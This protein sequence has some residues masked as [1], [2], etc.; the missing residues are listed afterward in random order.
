MISG[1]QARYLIPGINT[2]LF[3]S[4]S[5]IFLL[6][7]TDLSSYHPLFVKIV[8]SI[9]KIRLDWFLKKN[10]LVQNNLFRFRRSMGTIECLWTFVGQVYKSFCDKEF[11][12]SSFIDTKGA[13]NT[14]HIPTLISVLASLHVPNLV[15]NFISSL[16]S[17]RRLK[18]TFPSGSVSYSLSY[19]GISQGS[20]LSPLSFNV[21]ISPMYLSLISLNFKV[22]LYADNIVLF[23]SN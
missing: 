4:L 16:F 1:F 13:F 21:Y 23:S 5:P 3:F 2:M 18:F 12:S 7:L 19:R 22:L 15:C 11:L 9:I 14:V 20:Y 17:L 10:N 6:P 8:E